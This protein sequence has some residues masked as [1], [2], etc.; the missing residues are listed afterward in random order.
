VPPTPAW[1]GRRVKSV[2]QV[3]VDGSVGM[4]VAIAAG[5][6]SIETPHAIVE[7]AAALRDAADD[8]AKADAKAKLSELLNKYFEDDMKRRQDELTKIEAR[9]KK[10]RNL[11]DKRRE[12]QREIIDLQMKVLQNEADGLGFFNS[13]SLPGLPQPPGSIL[14]NKFMQLNPWEE[15]GGRGGWSRYE[16]APAAGFGGSYGAASGTMPARP[17]KAP[18]AGRAVRP[19]KPPRAAQPARPQLP[20]EPLD[21]RP[22]E[23]PVE[24]ESAEPP[25]TPV[26]ETPPPEVA[27]AEVAPADEAPAEGIPAEEPSKN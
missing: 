6:D 19:P 4:P 13:G 17:S 5:P 25:T 23:L 2:G 16:S 21:P 12:K 15:G 10:L 26:A 9:L 11:L 1:P 22:K 27:P 24:P 8:E 7:A 20:T 14:E 3:V 18:P